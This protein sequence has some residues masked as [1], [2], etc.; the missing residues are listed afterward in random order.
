MRNEFSRFI[1]VI[2]KS[3]FL[4]VEGDFKSPGEE[5]SIGFSGIIP[6]LDESYN[7]S[8]HSDLQSRKRTH[9]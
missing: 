2:V 8:S 6:S 1:S 5:P 4:A 3:V 7:E 9:R